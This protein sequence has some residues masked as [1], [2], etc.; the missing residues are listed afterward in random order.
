MNLIQSPLQICLIS[1]SSF[2]WMFTVIQMKV[3]T[4]LMNLQLSKYLH[5]APWLDMTEHLLACMG[6]SVQR[7][8]K[9]LTNCLEG[10]ALCDLT[11]VHAY[12]ATLI[13]FWCGWSNHFRAKYYFQAS[14]TTV[15]PEVVG[16]RAV[17]SYIVHNFW[18]IKWKPC[19][20]TF[21]ITLQIKTAYPWKLLHNAWC[22][23]VTSVQL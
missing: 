9:G 2:L 14:S 3:K 16:Q 5:Y 21:G 1:L 20:S 19:N 13:N 11:C 23:S 4:A 17:A 6:P 8:S 7:D 10:F 12:I 22:R 15:S 18:K